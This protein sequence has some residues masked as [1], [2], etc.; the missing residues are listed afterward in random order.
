MVPY[1]TNECITRQ[2]HFEMFC[3]TPTSMYTFKSHL[4]N[5][6]AFIGKGFKTH[7]I[8]VFKHH[9]EFHQNKAECSFVLISP[10]ITTQHNQA[11]HFLVSL[12]RKQPLSGCLKR[13]MPLPGSELSA[14]EIHYPCTDRARALCLRNMQISSYTEL[15]AL[16]LHPISLPVWRSCKNKD[17][18]RV[19]VRWRPN[20]GK[21]QL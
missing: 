17:P 10:S 7:C 3:R 11:F 9:S 14:V 2:F 5:R 12:Q 4:V 19:S 13:K 18:S 20:K 21:K 6:A 8:E 15:R 1:F 16:T